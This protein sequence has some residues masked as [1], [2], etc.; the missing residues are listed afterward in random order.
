MCSSVFLSVQKTV[1]QKTIMKTFNKQSYINANYKVVKYKKVMFSEDTTVVPSHWFLV[2]KFYCL[3]V[4]CCY[5]F[6]GDLGSL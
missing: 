1:K 4:Y 2:H 6:Q 5:G 3:L